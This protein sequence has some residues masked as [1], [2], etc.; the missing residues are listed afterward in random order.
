MQI[1]WIKSATVERESNGKYYVSVLY[2][3]DDIKYKVIPKN[4]VGIDLGVKK[5]LTLSDGSCYDNNKYILK[6][7]KRIK[8]NKKKI[9][10]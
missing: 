4:V 9:L 5:L 6:Y 10:I 1:Q 7:E 2:E 3:Q 8:R